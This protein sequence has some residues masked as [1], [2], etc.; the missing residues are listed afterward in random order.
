[1]IRY[2]ITL[3][4]VETLIDKYLPA[5][6]DKARKR[7]EKSRR[8]GYFDD[9]SP[10]W[11][12]IKPIYMRLQ[13]NK[14]AYCERRLEGPDTKPSE[15]ADI[16]AVPNGQG[17]GSEQVSTTGRIEHDVEHYR[18]KSSVDQ[19]PDPSHRSYASLAYAFPT[20][21]ADRGYHLL[22]YSLWNY[23]VACKTC[24]SE[25]KGTYFPIAG[26][27]IPDGEDPE[28]LRAEMPYL[29][30][31]I[32]RF[33]DDPQNLIGFK[34]VLPIPIG[35]TQHEQRRGEVTIDFFLLH[36]RD[37]LRRERSEIIR[38]LFFALIIRDD[39]TKPDGWRSLAAQSIDTLTSKSERHSSC[40]ISFVKIWET[41]QTEAEKLATQALAIIGI[42]PGQ[43]T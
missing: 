37:T 5:W 41:N 28:L 31:P 40:A 30:Y 21:N 35:K 19:W 3:A 17:A 14:C 39:H 12:E 22:A 7:T 27:R 8:A 32:G 43:S 1:M 2:D 42:D 15:E 13:S 4:E 29:I 9:P 38:G 6:R 16:A 11:S 23:A 24:N 33:D 34:G 18:P 25:L 36:K 10:I 26:T 20:G